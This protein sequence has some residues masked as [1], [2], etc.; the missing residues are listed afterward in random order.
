MQYTSPTT[1]E[2]MYQALKDIFFYYRIKRESFQDVVLQP[3]Q[4]QRLS[5]TPLTEA[6]LLSKAQTLNEGEQYAY[7]AKYLAEINKELAV[8]NAKLESLPTAKMVRENKVNADFDQ[9]VNKLNLMLAKN[10]LANS[11]IGLDKLAQLDVERNRLLAEIEAEYQEKNA[12]LLAEQ[13]TLLV[14]LE[15]ADGYCLEKAEKENLAKKKELEEAQKKTEME[16]FK[17]NNGIDEKEQRYANTILQINAN[18]EL[19][20][21]SIQAGEFTKDQLV[22]M[23]YYE[24]VINCVCAYYDRLG[25]LEAAREITNDRKIVQYLDDYYE[26]IVYLYQQRALA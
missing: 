13:Q 2:E 5:F 1:K 10:G 3:L 19:K 23:G 8:V 12:L 7:K 6:E 20:F 16:V 18:L 24:D 9:S 15:G 11:S 25:I 21:L 22:E 4:L 14:S 17:Y 26:S